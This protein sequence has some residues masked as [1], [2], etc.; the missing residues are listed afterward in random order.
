LEYEECWEVE[1]C[2]EFA[3]SCVD[4]KPSQ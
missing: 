3:V 4:E 1:R 2:E